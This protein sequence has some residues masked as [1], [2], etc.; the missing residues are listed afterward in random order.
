MADQNTPKAIT[1]DDVTIATFPLPQDGKVLVLVEEKVSST[2][3]RGRETGL[4]SS[5]SVQSV[6]EDARA[7]EP[8]GEVARSRQRPASMPDGSYRALFD[9]L[10]ISTRAAAA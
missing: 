6:E 7:P 8:S 4:R 10:G 5:R 9:D 2:N 1:D 3:E